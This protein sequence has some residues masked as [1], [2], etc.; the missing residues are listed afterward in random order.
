MHVVIVQFPLLQ[1]TKSVFCARLPLTSQS[2]EEALAKTL[3]DGVDI[4]QSRQSAENQ[5]LPLNVIV[6]WIGWP[7]LPLQ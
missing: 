3:R 4:Y 7:S 5:G 6:H 1:G 2:A